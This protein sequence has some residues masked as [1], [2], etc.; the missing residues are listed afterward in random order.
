MSTLHLTINGQ[1]YDLQCESGQEAELT[2]L[3]E[4]LSTRLQR[5]D[6]SIGTVA[7]SVSDQNMRLVIHSLMMLEEMKESRQNSR[8]R[9]GRD[10]EEIEEMIAETLERIAGK[11][12]AL[13]A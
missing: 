8:K 6:H 11:L 1:A 13:A 2:Q 12:E 4:E 9:A 10:R 3:A 5:L 7:Q